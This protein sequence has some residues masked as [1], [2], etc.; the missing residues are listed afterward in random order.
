MF[1]NRKCEET[2]STYPAFQLDNTQKLEQ[3]TAHWTW[4]GLSRATSKL[5]VDLNGLRILSPHLHERLKNLLYASG[6]N[7]TEHRIMVRIR[8][9]LT[10]ASDKHEYIIRASLSMP[11][12]LY[13]H[14]YRK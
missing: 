2:D 8:Y 6:V 5:K 12:T 11:D 4:P 1:Y 10:L 13:T 9:S 3:L 7:L 14:N